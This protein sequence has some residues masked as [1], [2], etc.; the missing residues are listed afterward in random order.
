MS[1]TLFPARNGHGAADGSTP[2]ISTIS[3]RNGGGSN[4]ASANYTVPAAVYLPTV[5]SAPLAVWYL[6]RMVAGYTGA[7]IQV[8]RADGATMDVAQLSNG[9]PDKASVSLWALGMQVRIRTFYDQTGNGRHCVQTD[10]AQMFLFDAAGLRGQSC[11]FGAFTAAQADGWLDVVAG[12]VRR[13]RRMPIPTSVAFA[14]ENYSVFCTVDPKSSIYNDIMLSFARVTGGTEA[15]SYGTSAGLSGLYTSGGP[16]NSTTARRPRAQFQTF[17]NTS[18][19]SNNKFFQDGLTIASSVKWSDPL[20]GG[21]WG[22]SVGVFSDFMSVGDNYLGV[23]I[24]PTALSDAD[25]VKVRQAVDAAFGIAAPS[26]V[27]LVRVGDSIEYAALVSESREGRAIS[28]LVRQYLKGN[29]SIHAMGISSQLLTGGGGLAANAATREDLLI[30]TSFPTRALFG[31][32]GGNDIATNGNTPGF[33]ATLYTAQGT[34][35]AARRSAG[36]NK[37][38]LRTITPRAWSAQQAIEVASYNALVRANSIGVDAIADVAAHPLFSDPTI[39]NNLTYFQGDTVHP[40]SYLDEILA[41][42]EAAA[43]NSVI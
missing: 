29:P 30:D 28:R 9:L 40:T 27:Q 35:I 38:I 32:I 25:A 31:Q 22:D 20:A 43:I 1:I 21:F 16:G 14:F 6:R 24:Y 11:A 15:I 5:S 13:P 8:Q 2:N 37:F 34:Y 12:N 42:I 18:T 7:L 10:F 19:L 17:G 23:A 36:F 26:N 41:P 39:V 4:A 3:G 33:G